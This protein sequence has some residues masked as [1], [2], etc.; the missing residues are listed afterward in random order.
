MRDVLN[1]NEKMFT[2]IFFPLKNDLYTE[3]FGNI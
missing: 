2:R 1:L 3:K